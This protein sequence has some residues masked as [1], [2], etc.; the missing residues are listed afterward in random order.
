MAAGYS[1][2]RLIA[3]NT[4]N[5]TLVKAAPGT[6]NGWHLAN[7]AAYAVYLKLYDSATTPTAGAGTPKLTIGV[8]AGAM[9]TINLGSDPAEAIVFLSG[10]GFTITKLAADADTTVVVAGDLVAN[11]LYR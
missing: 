4:T 1:V 3:A 10:I 2:S 9:G 5:A 7:P 6:V 11:L 8:P